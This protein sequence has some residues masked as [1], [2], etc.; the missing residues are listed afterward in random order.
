METC[1]PDTGAPP[2]RIMTG[3]R[4]KMVVEQLGEPENVE[5]DVLDYRDVRLEV[6]NGAIVSISVPAVD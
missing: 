1:D 4:A 6:R 3:M 5:E 2:L